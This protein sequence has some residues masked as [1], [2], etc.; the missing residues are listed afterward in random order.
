MK[1]IKPEGYFDGQNKIL[2]DSDGCLNFFNT[3]FYN[4]LMCF[5]GKKYTEEAK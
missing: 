3:I 4:F 1:K 2:F 5:K